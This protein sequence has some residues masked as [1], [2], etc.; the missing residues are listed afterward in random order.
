MRLFKRLIF[1]LFVTLLTLSWPTRCFAG[2]P[3]G[4]YVNE[5]TAT[6]THFEIH[7]E[8]SNTSTHYATN[9]WINNVRAYLD[10]A[11]NFQTPI[12][13]APPDPD[14]V[15]RVDV[16]NKEV[17]AYGET[18]LDI[19][20][21]NLEIELDNDYAGTIV[22]GEEGL[23]MTTAHEFF[24]CVQLNWVDGAT[25]GNSTYNW[26]TEGSADWMADQMYTQK[27][28]VYQKL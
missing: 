23:K 22:S 13:Q 15:I 14:G 11:W 12:W 8:G 20:S 26:F 24:H 18:K 27:Q 19:L 5:N 3:T 9:N 28:Q 21:G 16:W 6:T 17:E 7:W 4:G 25:W 1:G 10:N 2:P